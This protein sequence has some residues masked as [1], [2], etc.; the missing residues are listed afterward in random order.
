MPSNII[1]PLLH[2]WSYPTARNLTHCTFNIF[3]GTTACTDGDVRLQDGATESSGRVEVCFAGFW[4]TVCDDFWDDRDAAVV[5]RQL[6]YNDT[7]KLS[8]IGVS[9]QGSS[10]FVVVELG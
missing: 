9:N 8:V 4:G 10:S 3:A 6:G 2:H 7:G 5:C 1:H